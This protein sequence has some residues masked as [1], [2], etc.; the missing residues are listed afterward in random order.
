[1]SNPVTK[2]TGVMTPVK[3]KNENLEHFGQAGY[4]VEPAKND[5]DDVGVKMDVDNQIYQFAQGDLEALV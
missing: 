4:V 5:D 3:V 2:Y 1:M